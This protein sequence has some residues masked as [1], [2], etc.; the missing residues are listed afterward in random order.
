MARQQTFDRELMVDLAEDGYTVREI[1]E[2]VGAKS[3]HYVRTA[4]KRLG[5]KA[6]RDT[7]TPSPDR[8]DVPKAKALSAAGWTVEQIAEE[9]DNL[10][11]IE[12]IREA[13]HG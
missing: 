10:F 1:A 7:R 11:P 5:I 6:V 8:L 9:F 12:K 4:L 3:P 13:I 2:I